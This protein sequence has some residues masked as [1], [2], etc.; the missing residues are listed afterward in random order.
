MKIYKTSIQNIDGDVKVV[1]KEE[2]DSY[3]KSDLR[4]LLIAFFGITSLTHL[5]YFLSSYNKVPLIG[6][7]YNK[8]I[9]NRNNFVRW[10][11]YAITATI[12]INI[13]ARSAGISEEDTLL[14]TNI[15]IAAVMLQGQSIEL[16]LKEKPSW[17]KVQRLNFCD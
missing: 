10:F 17:N 1:L 2:K 11:E 12:M 7:V 4:D 3:L 6:G 13:V 16:A 15:A 8:M 14:L 5:F 9:Q